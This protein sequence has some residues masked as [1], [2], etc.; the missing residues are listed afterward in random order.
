[1]STFKF[2]HMDSQVSK[3]HLEKTL[4]LLH[5]IVFS[6][7]K[8]QLITYMGVFGSVAQPCPTLC[9]P[10]TAGCQA[11][12]SFTVSQSLLKLMSIKLV[13]LP[14][15]SHFLSSPSPPTFNLSQ[16][17]GL[18]KRVRFLHRWPKYWCFSF[19]VSPSNEH[20]GLISFRI[21]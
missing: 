6:L 1:M 21:N 4:S 3:Q 5:Y 2:L 10:W 7:A 20:S 8:G 14:N 19:S 18:F 11:S 9:D 17:Q 12:L 13:M 15:P 16:H